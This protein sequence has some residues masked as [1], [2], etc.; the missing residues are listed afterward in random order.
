MKEHVEKIKIKRRE[1]TGE[2][3]L[4]KKKKKQEENKKPEKEMWNR[5]NG[6]NQE[7][8]DIKEHKKKSLKMSKTILKM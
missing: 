4:L 5:L 8:K 3:K 1:V 6:L 7:F 2:N